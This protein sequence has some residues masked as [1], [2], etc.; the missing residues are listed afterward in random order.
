MVNRISINWTRKTQEINLYYFCVFLR[1]AEVG[2][3]RLFLGDALENGSY[4]EVRLLFLEK[5][6]L[7]SAL[8]SGIL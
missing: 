4:H 8:M 1:L 2:G 3:K 7:K 6:D 5:K